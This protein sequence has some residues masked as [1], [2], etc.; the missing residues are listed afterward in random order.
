MFYPCLIGVIKEDNICVDIISGKEYEIVEE[1]M[2]YSKITSKSKIAHNPAC[3]CREIDNSLE[4]GNRI[5]KM[6]E[7]LEYHEE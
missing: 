4:E 1:A 7:S 3:I 5:L 6:M 2:F